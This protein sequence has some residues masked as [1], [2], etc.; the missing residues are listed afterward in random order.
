MGN[1]AVRVGRRVRRDALNPDA[2]EVAGEGGSR[3]ALAIALPAR[4]LGGH[5]EHGCKRTSRPSCVHA[6]VAGNDWL[7]THARIVDGKTVLDVSGKQPMLP[8]ADLTQLLQDTTP[9]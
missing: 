7:T 5:C 9:S 2:G 3:R 4:P 8:H 6:A 1:R